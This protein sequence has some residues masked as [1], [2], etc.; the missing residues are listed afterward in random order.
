MES[1]GQSTEGEKEPEKVEEQETTTEW[2]FLL[3]GYY[4]KKVDIIANILNATTM[5]KLI[6]YLN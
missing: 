4:N 6:V 3:L 2:T 5:F 1:T